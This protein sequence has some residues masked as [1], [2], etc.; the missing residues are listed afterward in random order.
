MK[1][2]CMAAWA[3][4]WL[5]AAHP[6]CALDEPGPGDEPEPD[7]PRAAGR[8]LV[9]MPTL[10][11]N[12]FWADELLR[13][14]WRIQRNVGS[15]RYRLLDGNNLRYASGTFAQCRTVLDQLQR[16]RNLPPMQG[17]AVILLHGIADSRGQMHGL[18]RYLEQK[19]G[20]RV[21]NVSYP[22]TRQGIAEHAKGLASVVDHLDGIE[23]INFA[24]YSLGNL[25]IRRYLADQLKRD[26]GKPDP[27]FKRMVMLGPPNHGAE[28]ATSLGDNKLFELLLGKSGQE[29][30]PLWAWEEGSLVTPPFEFGIVA[31]GCRDGRGFNP[32]LPGDDDGVVTVASTRLA[33]ASD[34]IVVRALHALLPRESRVHEVTLRFL[35]HGYFV[36]PDRRKPV[37]KEGERGEGRREKGGGARD[38]G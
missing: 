28:L 13:H 12:Q 29:L 3:F 10:G 6:A 36:A 2:C 1:R 19:G 25:V 11:G 17:K 27:R 4:A 30:G 32:L 22:S 24:G 14:D 5:L 16:E 15:G 37:G 31:G 33:G 23:E 20:Y 38:D 34:F 9:P 35:D 26:S 8:E 21:F 18:A 7:A